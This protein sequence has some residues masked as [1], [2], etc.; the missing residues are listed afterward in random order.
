MDDHLTLGDAIR[1]RDNVPVKTVISPEDK[2][3]LRQGY[4]IKQLDLKGH[5]GDTV[6][7]SDEVIVIHYYCGHTVFFYKPPQQQWGS[8]PKVYPDTCPFGDPAYIEV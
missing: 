8:Q 7:C 5:L 1:L 2:R 3:K 4:T 6:F